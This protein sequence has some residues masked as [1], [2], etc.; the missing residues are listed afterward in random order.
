[1]KKIYAAPALITH[2]NVTNITAFSGGSNR[3]DFLFGTDGHPVSGVNGHGSLDACVT[4]PQPT[5]GSKCI[6]K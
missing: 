4:N 6:L 5:P 1:M 2:G 3:T